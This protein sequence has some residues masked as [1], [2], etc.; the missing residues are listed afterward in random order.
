M[1]PSS[2]ANAAYVRNACLCIVRQHA[3]FQ[4]IL[5]STISLQ[6]HPYLGIA[7]GLIRLTHAEYVSRVPEKHTA[8]KL[9]LLIDPKAARQQSNFNFSE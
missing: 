7:L 6:R 1:I 4:V 3:N 5:P 9:T 2:D 8:E